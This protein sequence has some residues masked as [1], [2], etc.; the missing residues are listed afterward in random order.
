V[1]SDRDMFIDH[2]LYVGAHTRM[3]AYH[4]YFVSSFSRL[5]HVL[6]K[7][8]IGETEKAGAPVF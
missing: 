4:C 7:L 3:R 6:S 2:G 5:F 8:G 1:D